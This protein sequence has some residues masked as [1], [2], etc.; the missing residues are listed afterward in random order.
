MAEGGTTWGSTT[1]TSWLRHH[2]FF[3]FFCHRLESH[4]NILC[5]LG[6][7]LDERH[8]KLVSELLALFEINLTAILH[9][10]FVADKNLANTCLG[11]LFNF[12]DPSTHVVE[13]FP[14]SHVIHYNDAL[15]A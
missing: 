4:V 10:A 13:G 6:R 1:S 9:I 2:L 12:I 15:C 5:R 11:V 7:R 14:V 3:D 8:A